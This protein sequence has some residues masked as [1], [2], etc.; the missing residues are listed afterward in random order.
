MPRPTFQLFNSM[1][2]AVEPIVPLDPAGKQISLYVCGPTIYNYGHIGNFR[3]YVAVDLL[4]RAL[5][6][7]GYD[8][9]H[10]MQFTDVDDKTIR[11]AREKN[12][13]LA[14]F[15]ALFR[16]AFLDDAKKLNIEIPPRTPNATDHIPAMIALIQKPPSRNTAASAISTWPASSPAPGSTRTNTK[17]KASAIS[18]SGKNGS[19]P[20]ATS[21]GIP[22]GAAAGPAG[23]SNV[24][25]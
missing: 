15:T 4:R 24:P 18:S 21:A 7:F 6:H 8:V 14:E 9:D 16:Q 10:V 5:R 3:T 13:P 22:P 2:R 25:P 19:P 11:G 1:T 17:R 20:T 12:L 23:T